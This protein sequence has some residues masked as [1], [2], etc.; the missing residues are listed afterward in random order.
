LDLVKAEAFGDDDSEQAETHYKLMES[1]HLEFPSLKEF[2]NHW[3]TFGT[4]LILKDRVVIVPE[5]QDKK[6]AI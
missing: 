3:Q 1:H 6:G 2:F 4:S 5:V